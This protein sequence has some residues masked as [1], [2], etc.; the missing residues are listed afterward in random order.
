MKD[1]S[2]LPLEEN[3]IAMIKNSVEDLTIYLKTGQK[4]VLEKDKVISVKMIDQGKS[5][6]VACTAIL[7]MFGL[8][9]GVMYVLLSSVRG[10]FM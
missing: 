4:I 8:V 7:I 1:G 10:G 5:M 3:D 6:T 2:V 9:F